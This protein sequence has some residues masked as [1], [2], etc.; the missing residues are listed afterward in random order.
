MSNLQSE[1]IKNVKAEE[2]TLSEESIENS[3]CLIN[4]PLSPRPHQQEAIQAIAEALSSAGDDVRTQCVMACGTGKTVVAAEI[5]R[6]MGDT[7]LI[8][9]PTLGL[10]SQTIKVFKQQLQ[11]Q[12]YKF[13]AVCSDAGVVTINA[14]NVSV[15]DSDIDCE[16]TTDVAKTAEF[17]AA[18]GKKVIFST[19]NSL[20][21]VS[22][23]QATGNHRFSGI[24]VD[25]A[26]RTASIAGAESTLVLNQDLVPADKRLFLT[27]TPRFTSSSDG[28]EVMSMDNSDMYGSVC[29][30]L[31][32]G[33]AI[34]KGLLADYRVVVATV[35]KDYLVKR[36]D[37]QDEQALR[38]AVGIEVLGQL[39]DQGD[40]SK[41]LTFHN[42][43]D[44]AKEFAARVNDFLE[45]NVAAHSVDGMMPMKQRRAILDDF[46][47]HPTKE[48]A[49]VSN[50]NCLSEGIDVPA[51]DGILFMDPRSSDVDIV[52]AIGRAIRRSDAD[53]IGTI[54]IPVLVSSDQDVDGAISNSDFKKVAQVLNGIK[55]HDD[56]FESRLRKALSESSDKSKNAEREAGTIDFIAVG[57]IVESL[58]GQIS[59]KFLKSGIS[60]VVTLETIKEWCKEYSQSFGSL[61]NLKSDMVE[62]QAVSWTAIQGRFVYGSY[63]PY[64]SLNQFLIKE[65]GKRGIESIEAI[66]SW[67]SEYSKSFDKVPNRQSEMVPGQTVP[68]RR[69]EERFHKGNY[70]PYKSLPEFFG[71]EFG[72]I[73]NIDSLATVKSWCNEHRRLFGKWPGQG[74]ETVDGQKVSWSA[75]NERFKNEHYPPY[76]T[77]KEF[78]KAEMGQTAIGESLD[79]VKSWCET[80]ISTFDKLP[81]KSSDNVEGQTASWPAID[82]RFRNG[83]YAPYTTLK[84]FVTREF[85]KK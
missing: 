16:V 22:Q 78:L 55:S 49:I 65:F 57:D 24:I 42:R 80:Y 76:K 8:T 40:V 75:V 31:S 50:C 82:M 63:P 10:V 64:K 41:V 21:V 25:E 6:E 11:G 3:A 33:D 19:L 2:I 36:Y 28:S 48:L 34:D 37:V 7:V 81:V 13:L 83:S 72:K 68:W 20:D 17:L 84:D 44:G 66:Q 79:T 61:P 73:N 18:S 47:Q 74:S 35:D 53:K 15:N 67:C 58:K 77:L 27:A 43:V 14:D 29:H 5:A 12:E 30:K 4:A 46:A 26:H 62:G 38:Y 71:V 32:L 70:P 54:I 69:I 56:R 23:A 59:T 60:K 39:Y 51:I 45:G 52:Q 85:G 9:L 1:P